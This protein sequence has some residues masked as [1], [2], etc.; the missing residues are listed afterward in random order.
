MNELRPDNDGLFQG[1][2][3]YTFN[4]LGTKFLSVWLLATQIYF[5]SSFKPIYC[6]MINIGDVTSY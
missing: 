5:S 4:I 2:I 1:Y 3:V 6:S